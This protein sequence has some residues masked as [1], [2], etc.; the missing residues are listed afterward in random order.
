MATLGTRKRLGPVT[1]SH[2]RG[3]PRVATSLRVIPVGWDKAGSFGSR[4]GAMR[5]AGRKGLTQ[6]QIVLH[7]RRVGNET[8]YTLFASRPT[9]KGQ[10][11]IRGDGTFGPREMIQDVAIPVV[12]A[13][14][15]LTVMNQ[16]LS[17][18]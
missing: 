6:T 9:A 12:V 4:E 7:R 17:T 18:L 16:A 10:R 13:G 1:R 11:R 14:A 5:A 3:G 8:R 2:T 15:G